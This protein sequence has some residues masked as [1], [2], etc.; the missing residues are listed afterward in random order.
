MGAANT[1]TITLSAY[2]R[3]LSLPYSGWAWEFKRRDPALRAAA[4]RQSERAACI[5]RR[6][7]GSDI[8]RLKHRDIE[9]ETFGLHY[10]PDPAL[11]A[12]ETVPF[13]LPE[14]MTTQLDAASE[15]LNGSSNGWT[16]LHWRRIPGRKRFLIAPG[17]RS[18]LAI[19]APG[20]AIQL[21]I[22]ED[23]LPVP[24]VSHLSLRLG[25]DELGDHG[26]RHVEAFASF[27]R[28]RTPT[29]PPMRG[30]KPEALLRAI[31]ALD[32][33][34][35]GASQRQIADAIFG[36]ERVAEDWQGG[37]K[38]YKSKTR[39]LIKKGVTLM[40]TGYRNLL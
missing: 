22:E 5:H 7:D 14:W 12:F 36:A 25:A 17:R 32:G 40:K 34:L 15:A 9:A 30:Y 35:A 16:P 8:I 21:A 2:E 33:T 1:W 39:R 37:A 31:I 4:R 27:C 6:G 26:F 10:I 11:S 13:W 20:Y 24:H 23:D 19:F 38:S 28:H 18:K 29:P 3:L